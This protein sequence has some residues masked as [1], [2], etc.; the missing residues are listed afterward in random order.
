[1]AALY[2]HKNPDWFGILFPNLIWHGNRKQKVLY[3]TFD[4][5]PI[6]EMTEWVLKVLSD[7][8]VKATF[9]TVAHNIEKH[10]DIFNKVREQGHTVANH[11]FNH[12][13]SWR[14]SFD[15][16][17]L[18][19]LKAQ[20]T[21]LANGATNKEASLFRPPYG[22]LTR[23]ISLWLKKNG[24]Q[25]VMWDVLSADFDPTLSSVNCLKKTVNATR[26]GSIIIFHDN[27][28][29]WKNLEYVLP[30]YIEIMQAKGFVFKSLISEN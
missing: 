9:F 30:R 4:D 25:T 7:Y 2:W 16:Y 15:K 6:P 17:T 8:Q 1:M 21:L 23:Q 29:A 26:N 14:N 18:N 19:V 11:T 28:K 12:L 20:E 3:L 5:G 22:K 24:F 13:D 27:I 10:P